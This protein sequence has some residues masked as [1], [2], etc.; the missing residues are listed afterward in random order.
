MSARMNCEAGGK[1]KRA[2]PCEFA[3]DMR[4]KVA[5]QKGWDEC[6]TAWAA[7]MSGIVKAL[8]PPIKSDLEQRGRILALAMERASDR[9]DALEKAAQY[10]ETYD[11]N[12]G[13]PRQRRCLLRDIADGLRVM[14]AV[15]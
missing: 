6:I 4:V 13:Y 1:C 15:K 10:V 5:K 8:N 2:E 7:H 9:D 14:K 3:C 12:G 11:S